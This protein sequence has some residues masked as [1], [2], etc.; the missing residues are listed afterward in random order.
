MF[1]MFVCCDFF[2]HLN[3]TGGIL[4]GPDLPI[5][6]DRFGDSVGVETL[7]GILR[8]GK[9]LGIDFWSGRA[10][11]DY[12]GRCARVSVLLHHF[13]GC[14]SYRIFSPLDMQRCFPDGVIFILYPAVT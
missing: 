1:F 3:L 10:I 5:P 2:R 14:T 12:G 13:F 9:I 8:A 11:I 4:S 7:E 6:P